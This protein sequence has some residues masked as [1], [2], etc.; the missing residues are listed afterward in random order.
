MISSLIIDD[1]TFALV[2]VFSRIVGGG[3]SCRV[4][5][6]DAAIVAGG[7]ESAVRSTTSGELVVDRSIGE[8]IVPDPGCTLIGERTVDTDEARS[9]RRVRN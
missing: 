2:I 5:M 9:S 7:G 3:S 8:V 1:G 6:L 4:V